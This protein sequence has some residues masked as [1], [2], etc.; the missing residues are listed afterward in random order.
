MTNGMNG[1]ALYKPR[2]CSIVMAALTSRASALHI[3]YQ[4]GVN[5]VEALASFADQQRSPA[6]S[7]PHELR[8]F[9]RDVP[10]IR[11][12]EDKW[13]K[14]PGFVQGTNRVGAHGATSLVMPQ[15]PRQIEAAAILEQL[16][17]R[18]RLLPQSMQPDKPLRR[19]VIELVARLI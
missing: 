17:P 19:I 8:A 11:H 15:Q 9:H 10:A 2:T 14:R 7:A 16:L 5:H 3:P 18:L 6:G 12:V 4:Q 1:L 13:Q